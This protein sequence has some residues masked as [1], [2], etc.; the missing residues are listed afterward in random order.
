MEELFLMWKNFKQTFDSPDAYVSLALGLAVVL[1][2]GM[3]AFNY[4][5]AKMPASSKTAEEQKTQQARMAP[6]LPTKYTVKD[7]DTLWSI[8]EAFFKSGY[9]WVDIAT[10]NNFENPDYVTAGQTI[11]IPNVAPKIVPTGE[12]SSAA[13]VMQAKKSTYA[14]VAGDSLWTISQKEYNGNGYK[15]TDI[16]SANNLTNPDLIFAGNVLTLP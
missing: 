8:S 13:T 10:T 1:V 15:W 3:I 11:I 2:I 7:G 9:N 16:A 12:V 14:V 6:T 4:I 5:K